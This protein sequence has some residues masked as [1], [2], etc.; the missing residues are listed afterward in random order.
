MRTF[1]VSGSRLRGPA[2][3]AVRRLTISVLLASLV[4]VNGC[5]TTSHAQQ[6]EVLG[7]IV[8]GVVG[9]QVG[10]GRGRTAAIIVGTLAGAMIGRH[11]GQSMD[12]TDRL[13]AAGA[14][15]D[16]RSGQPTTW[17]NPDT[18][19]RYTLTPTR[20]YEENTGPCREFQLDATV[21]GR[22][23][24]NVYGTACL[25]ADGSWLVR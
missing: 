11:I 7:G 5:E 21:G 14:L 22:T 13:T 18:G 19:Y 25:Q 4:L 9:S 10:G 24:Q 17:I 12:D 2:N 16:A 1:N 6:G 15:N 3:T 23:D 20:T 8:G